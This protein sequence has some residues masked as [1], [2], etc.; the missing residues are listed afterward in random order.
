MELK[1]EQ[2]KVKNY[3]ETIQSFIYDMQPEGCT[4]FLV[5]YL[6]DED[7]ENDFEITYRNK[8]KDYLPKMCLKYTLKIN[9]GKSYEEL[10]IDA[11]YNGTIALNELGVGDLLNE[12]EY[13]ND[14]DF[15]NILKKYMQKALDKTIEEVSQTVKERRIKAIQESIDLCNKTIKSNKESFEIYQQ[16][17]LR[18]EEQLKQ[19]MSEEE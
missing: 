4:K 14:N 19:V 8:L 3:K 16:R 5:K 11:L 7:I 17:L 18:Y 6:L 12:I 10:Y 13:Y 2:Y 1:I 9:K 15:Y